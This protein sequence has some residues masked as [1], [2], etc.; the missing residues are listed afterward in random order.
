MTGPSRAVRGIRDKLILSFGTLVLSL[1]VFVFV[2]FPSRLERQ[3][4][5]T[6]IAK[7]DAIRDMTALAAGA[8]WT[9]TSDCGEGLAVS[10]TG[11]EYLRSLR[12]GRDVW[13]DGQREDK[14]ESPSEKPE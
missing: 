6:V 1:A 3:A 8:D 5:Q 14:R 10:R 9:G 4:T 11:A 2:F 7:A 13:Y 12:D